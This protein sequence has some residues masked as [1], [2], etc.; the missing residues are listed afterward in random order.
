MLGCFCVPRRR[1]RRRRERGGN[2]V[3][4]SGWLTEQ[5]CM[6]GRCVEERWEGGCWYALSSV[7]G[8]VGG[9][10]GRIHTAVGE[11]RGWIL[12]LYGGV[13]GLI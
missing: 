1:R 10:E 12:C 7:G 4:V 8:G 2:V 3:L 5:R 11:C 6:E 9:R 13:R